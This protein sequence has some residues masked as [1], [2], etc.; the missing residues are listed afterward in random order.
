MF[1]STLLVSAM[2]M[3]NA[4][5]CETTI[6]TPI[7]TTVQSEAG[8]QSL[9]DVYVQDAEG[10]RTFARVYRSDSGRIYCIFPQ[11]SSRGSN[12]GTPQKYW[13]SQSSKRGF[14]YEVYYNSK[15]WYFNL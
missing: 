5:A 7:T 15:T 12:S 1:I 4:P 13:A 14:R 2:M 6:P 11:V 9:G 8:D 10:N 3:V